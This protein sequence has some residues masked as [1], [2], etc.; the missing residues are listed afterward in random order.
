LRTVQQGW[1]E[2]GRGQPG[3]ETHS[4]APGTFFY[5]NSFFLY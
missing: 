4:W 1:D 5:I 3:L 2:R